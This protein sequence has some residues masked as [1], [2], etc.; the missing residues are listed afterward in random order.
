MKSLRALLALPLLA[1]SLASA[2]G[3]VPVYVAPSPAPAPSELHRSRAQLE[4][5]VA[6]VALYPDAL[7][8]IMLPASTA[9]TDLVLA[10]RQMRENPRD[11]ALVEARPWD[12]SVKS[13]TAHPDVLLWMDDN[14]DWT[15]QLGEA[16]ASQPAEVMQAV[17][18]LR[19]TARANGVLADTPEQ[20]V[21]TEDAVVRIVPARPDVIYV[22]SY[23]PDI[24]LLPP[25]SW[26]VRPYL[27]FSFGV[28]TGSWLAFDC[29]WRRHTIWVGNRHRPWTGHDWRRPLVT[30]PV[31][32]VTA[33]G[34]PVEGRPWRPAARPAPPVRPVVVE[35]I[36]PRPLGREQG[37]PA[38]STSSPATTSRDPRPG[39]A[40]SRPAV[41]APPVNS[42]VPPPSS[43]AVNAPPRAAPTPSTPATPPTRVI[44]PTP[45][46]PAAPVERVT[47]RP[48][49]R[50]PSLRAAR[51]E[52]A[53]P[54]SASSG[55]AAPPRPP[56]AA[57]RQ[58]PTPAPN[59]PSSARTPPP[60]TSKPTTTDAAPAPA[61]ANS[62]STPPARSETSRNRDRRETAVP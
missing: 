62:T 59:P 46:S 5:L 39:S 23:E 52:R 22:P 53:D 10:A 61:T 44:T 17:Q 7:L 6:P 19:A 29:D 43:R 32:V 16:F 55:T 33:P 2:Q 27:G 30:A 1:G 56:A 9:P 15:R 3:P 50:G 60:S 26:T 35:V 20:R 4:Q 36:R 48:A 12:E 25:S 37:R 54:S 21:I 34:R 57:P 14:L 28:A 31:A 45:S 38:F 51:P 49:E 41:T 42:P 8:A 18:R 24:L 11:A 58:A 40:P 47:E 13:L